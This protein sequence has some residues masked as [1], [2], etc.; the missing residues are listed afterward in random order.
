MSSRTASSPRRSQEH[1]QEHPPPLSPTPRSNRN[2]KQ[3]SRHHR[4]N[5][6][7]NNKG[8]THEC[9]S[10]Q[11]DSKN[12][13]RL[14][15][16]HNNNNNT[17]H[18]PKQM[19]TTSS[20]ISNVSTAIMHNTFQYHPNAAV[21]KKCDDD[22][23]ILD[24]AMY[25]AAAASLVLTSSTCSSS[26]APTKSFHSN[27]ASKKDSKKEP[28]SLLTSVDITRSGTRNS[29]NINHNDTLSVGNT[30]SIR[31]SKVLATAMFS[32]AVKEQQHS[33]HEGLMKPAT[34]YQN[35]KNIHNSSNNIS[36]NG[37]GNAT[38]RATTK[39]ISSLGNFLHDVALPLINFSICAAH[40]NNH[41]PSTYNSCPKNLQHQQEKVYPVAA[42]EEYS[43]MAVA[44]NTIATTFP[45]K[46]DT[47]FEPL[48]NCSRRKNSKMNDLRSSQPLGRS[49]SNYK[50]RNKN[51]SDNSPSTILNEVKQENSSSNFNHTTSP[52]IEEQKNSI[53]KSRSIIQRID[54]AI[55]YCGTSPTLNNKQQQISSCN[56]LTSKIQRSDN[57]IQKNNSSR[58]TR[59]LSQKLRSS[60]SS[61]LASLS[62]MLNN[63]TN[64]L[65]SPLSSPKA[66]T[67]ATGPQKDEKSQLHNETK[68]DLLFVVAR[69]RA[70]ARRVQENPMHHQ[71][72]PNDN[73]V[74]S[75]CKYNSSPMIPRSPGKQQQQRLGVF[76]N[77]KCNKI[78]QLSPHTPPRQLSR[79]LSIK[80]GRSTSL[81]DVTPTTSPHSSSKTKTAR[82]DTLL[83]ATSSCTVATASTT[84]NTTTSSTIISSASTCISVETTAS[85][86]ASPV[87]N[88]DPN[89]SFDITIHD[90]SDSCVVGEEIAPIV[91]FPVTSQTLHPK[92]HVNRVEVKEKD[93][94][95]K[96]VAKQYMHCND[97]NIN[98]SFF[99]SHQ[100]QQQQVQPN[101]SKQ[102]QQQMQT[103]YPWLRV[104]SLSQKML[105]GDV[106][107]GDNNN[108]ISFDNNERESI[109]CKHSI[110]MKHFCR[111]SVP[112]AF[113]PTRKNYAQVPLQEF[114][115]V[116]SEPFASL[117]Q[118]RSKTYTSD[119]VKAS[120]KESMLALLGIDSILKNEKASTNG[121]VDAAKKKN[122][123][124]NNGVE[125]QEG[126]SSCSSKPIHH[127]CDEELSYYKRMKMACERFGIVPPFLVVINFVLPWGNFIIYMYRPDGTMG[128]PINKDRIDEPSERLWKEF[129][130]GDDT[131]RSKKLKFIPRIVVGPWM[132]KKIV[133]TN[134]AL[135][136]QK[137]PTSYYGY[138]RSESLSSSP[139][140]RRDKNYLEITFDVTKG[141]SMAN[142]ISNS[143]VGKAESISIDMA[144]LI[145]GKTEAELPEQVLGLCRVHRLSMKEAMT[146]DQ[147]KHNLKRNKGTLND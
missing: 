71:G 86:Y 12:L 89:G 2:R 17:H 142:S 52:F 91:L 75:S 129:L 116:C 90:H 139:G 34:S 73:D 7:S 49:S 94:D 126:S 55:N 82:E 56:I 37:F 93:G 95:E 25:R 64:S 145:E 10:I 58:I 119:K 44:H 108:D 38:K 109:H 76:N 19:T 99:L 18:E 3:R 122:I 115:H 117:C 110:D 105:F 1:Q 29:R 130:D 72:P 35:D 8:S 134:P 137:I 11:E 46:G 118:V 144:F 22:C 133:G 16:T 48:N 80:K 103:V 120:S 42:T 102:Q 138:R 33:H 136:G 66:S 67:G 70:Q 77:K 79:I 9:N 98:S 74:R 26:R 123:A 57:V 32:S 147:W 141:G 50:I 63:T 131:L 78:R 5:P 61:S 124:G 30:S 28:K 83:T 107:A 113:D 146:W 27:A 4:T 111:T 31:D 54:T 24:D 20:T 114:V 125:S 128:G 104:D 59:K 60:S 36:S 6:S 85:P 140:K 100:Q 15:L 39:N 13:S 40:T 96:D 121:G 87:V 132:I 65:I 127:C 92:N 88:E 43:T 97:C 14:P 101:S 41:I 23:D 47:H 112:F 81:I 69:S 45:L 21:M 62:V 68:S 84:A 135:I 106:H 53:H 143:V 51:N